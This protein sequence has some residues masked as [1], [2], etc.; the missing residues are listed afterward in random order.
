LPGGPKLDNALIPKTRR[1]STEFDA[2]EKADHNKNNLGLGQVS[3]V[4][5]CG[6]VGTKES[7]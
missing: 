5:V 6:A 2:S 3:R 7:V 1:N 4:N